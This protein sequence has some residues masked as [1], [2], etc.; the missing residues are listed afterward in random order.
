MKKYLILLYAFFIVHTD[1]KDVKIDPDKAFQYDSWLHTFGEVINIFESRYYKKIDPEEVMAKAIKAYSEQDPHSSFLDKKSCASL[2]EKM[3]GE[4]FGI[5]VVLPGDKQKELEFFP[6][7]ETVP[8]GP[9]DKAG[10]KQGDKVIQIDD[11]LVKGHETEEIMAKLK[12]EKGSKVT[13][14]IMREKYPEALTIEVTR[15]V[16]KD[17]MSLAYHFKDQNVYYLL[18]SIFS[19]KS[20]ENVESLLQI[21]LKNNA[22]GV[23]ID[24]R[25]NVGGLFDS[26]I[27]IAGLF[28]PKGSPVVSIK[29]RDGKVMGSW[30]TEKKPLGIPHNMPI[31][32]LVNNYTASASEILAGVLQAY[33]DKK[34]SLS[35]FI[36][37]TE[38]FGKGS[39]QEV[40]PISNEGALKLTTGLYYLAFDICIQGKGVTP[41]FPLEMRMPQTETMK[42]MTSQYGK[43][44]SMR[45]HIKPHGEEEKKEKDLKKDDTDK[46]WKDKR[47]ELLANDYYIQNTLD[48]ISLFNLGQKL[49]PQLF[50]KRSDALT[51]LRKH[52]V[53]DSKIELH[54]IQL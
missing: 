41:D 34:N 42:W 52:Y 33:A 20:A 40:I 5:G 54:D 11:M 26:A 21:A 19:E 3:K 17:E 8:G 2:Q 37:G 6:I 31:F 27:T 28:L 25:N 35:M 12:G 29:Q 43:E 9:A 1:A 49:N 47:R 15:D 23:V 53:L 22:Q 13:L 46:P 7:I 10:I 18:M 36:V 14:K 50:K 51:F 48:L 16:I 44:K 39:V 45:G 24:L 38:T 4:F 30:K 32:F